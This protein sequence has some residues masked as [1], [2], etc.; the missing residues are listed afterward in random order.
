MKN[1][2]STRV[3]LIVRSMQSA[4]RDTLEEAHNTGC[5]ILEVEALEAIS[6]LLATG[7]VNAVTA[8]NTPAQSKAEADAESE[9]VEFIHNFMEKEGA[10]KNGIWFSSLAAILSR[11][12][13]TCISSI[14]T[15][16]QEFRGED[17]EKK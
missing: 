13:Y 9:I 4:I 14:N 8:R 16:A 10:K 15:L 11:G 6:E 1:T 7:L 12:L 2:S 17:L 5:K 3:K